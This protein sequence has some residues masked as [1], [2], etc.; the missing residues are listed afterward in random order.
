MTLAPIVIFAFNR[1][2]V[3]QT[4]VRTLQLNP[5]AKDSDVYVFVDGARPE[6]AYESEKVKIVQDYVKSIT[7]FHSLSYKFSNT[8]K[9]LAPSII[10]GVTEVINQYG[11]CIVLEDDL[12]LSSNFLAWMNQCLNEYENNNRVFQI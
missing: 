8:N 9:K 6:K 2:D 7:G 10:A 12:I 4:L 11:K 1:V 3:L 5:E